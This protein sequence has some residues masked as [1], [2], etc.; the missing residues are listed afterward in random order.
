MSTALD[1]ITNAMMEMGAIAQ[2]ETPSAADAA[3][4]LSKLNRLFDQWNAR[5]LFVFCQNFNSY[6][7]QPNLQPHTI[8]P[9]GATFNV[10]IRPVKISNANI[11]LNNITPNVRF[12]L[13]IRDADWWA[14]NRVQGVTT[15]LPTDLYYQPSWPNGNLFLWPVPTVAYLVELETWNTNAAV[16]LTTPFLYPPGYEDAITYTLAITLCPAFGRAVDPTLLTLAVKAMQ[17]IQGV[18][19]SPPPG[20][21]LAGQGVPGGD[22]RPYFNYIS[23]L[24]R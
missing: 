1:I 7:I 8:G 18:N 15:T 23:G 5:K 9:T 10:P 17:T 16:S 19:S 13:K 24:S 2:G 12:A 4:A 20:I 6:T 3:F 11:V 14:A 21:V 22:Q